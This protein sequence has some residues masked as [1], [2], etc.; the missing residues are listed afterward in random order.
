MINVSV[1]VV[2]DYPTEIGTVRT[3]GLWEVFRNSEKKKEKEKY[4]AFFKGMIWGRYTSTAPSLLSQNE[5]PIL[6]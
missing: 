6:P 2:W 4:S 1:F 3:P 5:D